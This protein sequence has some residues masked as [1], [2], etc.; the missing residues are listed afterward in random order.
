MTTDEESGK[1]SL[2]SSRRQSKINHHTIQTSSIPWDD[3]K[4][5]PQRLS[6]ISTMKSSLSV[7]YRYL[8]RA[9]ESKC[10]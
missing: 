10:E 4:I 7:G 8:Y 2:S 6:T 1:D 3:E 9:D 5:K